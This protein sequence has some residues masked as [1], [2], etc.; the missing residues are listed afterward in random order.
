MID[1]VSVSTP[2]R[3]GA[4]R[5]W[6]ITA[7]C[8]YNPPRAKRGVLKNAFLKTSRPFY[9][10]RGN[11]AR[12]ALGHDSNAVLIPFLFR[13]V[14]PAP[15]LG[16]SVPCL[17]TEVSRLETVS[18]KA[19]N[20]SV[21]YWDKNSHRPIFP[22]SLLGRRGAAGPCMFPRAGLIP[23]VPLPLLPSRKEGGKWVY[24]KKIPC[25]FCAP[26]RDSYP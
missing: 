1:A 4:R 20:R 5:S 16:T 19:W 8:H 12:T 14:A 10:R 21:S 3:A 17:E 22:T 13:F 2:A 26:A 9:V 15:R 11:F 18:T 6:S 23:A 24:A 25:G 7:A